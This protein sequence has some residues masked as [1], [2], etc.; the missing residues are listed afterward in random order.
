MAILTPKQISKLTVA[1]RLFLERQALNVIKQIARQMRVDALR[2]VA[3]NVSPTPA[4]EAG[5]ARLAKASVPAAVRS[6]FHALARERMLA[7]VGDIIQLPKTTHQRAVDFFRKRME[8]ND[9]D[10]ARLV[11]KYGAHALGVH[12]KAGKFVSEK[13]ERALLAIQEEGLHVGSAV[14]QTALRKAFTESGIDLGTRSGSALL[15]TIVRT[16]TAMAQSAGQANA[17]RD[18]ALDEII[19]GYEYVTVGDSRVRPN[20]AAMHGT[21]APKD[22]PIWDTITPPNGFNCRCILVAIYMNELDRQEIDLP[23]DQLQVDVDGQTVIII[24]GPDPG[25]AFNP[26]DLFEDVAIARSAPAPLF[27]TPSVTP[28]PLRPTLKPDA[29]LLKKSLQPKPGIPIVKPDAVALKKEAGPLEK[30]LKKELE[31]NQ[32][33]T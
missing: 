10:L 32:P 9:A 15:E 17:R 14:K 23:P 29:A 26:A 24:P 25:F 33:E 20:H 3:E 11:D 6:H 18:P 8:I 16:Q 31:R 12:D 19:W 28:K 5:F 2:A 30:K 13:I 22:D 21:T 4:I 27:T 1:D 7:G